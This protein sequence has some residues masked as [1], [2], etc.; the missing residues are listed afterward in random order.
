MAQILNFSNDYNG[1]SS[2]KAERNL[3]TYGLNSIYAEDDCSAGIGKALVN[4]RLF[5]MLAATALSAFT[6]NIGAFCAMLILTAGYIGVTCYAQTRLS[7][8][9]RALKRLSGVKFRTVRDGKLTLVRK[10]YLVPDDIIV[11][12]AGECVPADAYLLEADGLAVDE[13]VITGSS[14]PVAKEISRDGGKTVPKK[15]CIYKNTL[16]LKGE[17]IARVFATGE[18]VVSDEKNI[19]EAPTAYEKAISKVTP[20]LNIAA[21]AVLA[22]SAVLSVIISQGTD[23]ISLIAPSLLNACGFA[24]CFT[25]PML[26]QVVKGYYIRGAHRLSRKHALVKNLNSLERLNAITCVCVEKSGTIT[27]SHLEV[28]S[29]FTSNDAMF[30]NV[31]V[32]A[33]EK[34][35]TNSIDSAILF[36]ASFGGADV[37]ELQSEELVA[38]YPFSEENKMAGNL[39]RVNGT[40]ILCVKGSPDVILAQCDLSAANMQSVASKLS[41]LSRNGEQV[42][43]VAYRTFED[44]DEIPSTLFGVVFSYIGLISF[45][46]STKDTIPFAVRSCY[47]SGVDVIMTTGDS[48]DT[49]VAIARKIGLREGKIVT[50]EMLRK[51][52]LYGDPLDLTDVNIFARVTP[53]QRREIVKMLQERGEIV[54]TSGDDMED[55]EVL[56]TADVGIAVSGGACPA[57]SEACNLLMG[58]ENFIAVVDAIKDCRQI[59]L[60]MKRSIKITLCALISLIL[61]SFV[62]LITGFGF[63]TPQLSSLLS[64]IIIPACALLFLDN[65]A[66]AKSEFKPSGLIGKGKV[67]RSFFPDTLIRAASLFIGILL[68]FALSMGL[69][70]SVRR[71]LVFFMFSLGL[72][73]QTLSLMSKTK[74]LPRM[75]KEKRSGFAF[76]GAGLITLLTLLLTF[77]PFVNTAFSLSTPD[78]S[79]ALIALIITVVSNGWFEVSKYIKNKK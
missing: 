77:V 9:E 40:K 2:E 76:L 47:K 67:D 37:K 12:H 50:G 74:T 64:L 33:C 18:D 61:L 17:A 6:G 21:L 70:A 45:T 54:A 79:V 36:N 73:L 71:S 5:I 49:A 3:E 42:L 69:D 59:H 65:A 32:L 57:A 34:N 29:V 15:N 4:P 26:V 53:E 72:T 25:P 60:N 56:R 16:V 30:T 41:E 52:K 66:D 55:V 39:W 24:L 22:I 51:A 7:E 46:N 78:L 28:A 35:P 13:S 48:E 38:S 31:S 63:F 10:E 62:S 23:I 1:L 58:D 19:H 75:I 20:Y 44:D 8:R 68:V 14:T 43:A 27:K 11:L